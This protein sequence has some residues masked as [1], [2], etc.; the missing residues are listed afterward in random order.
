MTDRDRINREVRRELLRLR[1]QS[2]RQGIGMALTDVGSPIAKVGAGL[3][4]LAGSKGLGLALL[5]RQI[6]SADG[7]ISRWRI[8][9]SGIALAGILWK[10]RK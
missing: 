10:S 8:V 5:S 4:W 9:L 3:R 7:K 2:Y 1:A 6:K